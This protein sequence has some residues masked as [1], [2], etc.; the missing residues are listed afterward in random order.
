MTPMSKP[1]RMKEIAVKGLNIDPSVTA[2][3]YIKACRLEK[4]LTMTA[5]S[6]IAGV[7]TTILWRLE[8][9]KSK[10]GSLTVKSFVCL[11]IAVGADIEIALDLACTRDP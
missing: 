7:S 3:S 5:A 8:H 6:K 10:A 11:C 2:G 1:Q 9:G 4:G